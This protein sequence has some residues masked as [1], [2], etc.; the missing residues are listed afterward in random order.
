M[1]SQWLRQGADPRLG[2]AAL[3]VIALVGAAGRLWA[4]PTKPQGDAQPGIGSIAG[5][6]HVIDG[7]TIEIGHVRIRL[8]GMDAPELHQTC[9]GHDGAVYECGRDATAVMLELTRGRRV[10]CIE[11]YH[12][13]YHRAVAICR[14][15]A[16]ELNAQMVQR[17][18]AVDFPRYSGGAYADDER[19]ARAAHLGIWSGRFELPWHWRRE[20]PR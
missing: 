16:G 20:H 15:D 14:T 12:D 19:E 2:I 17:G 11:R 9:Q 18:W 5:S 4:D 8:W 10:E 13:L 1:L 7:D 6:P 3:I